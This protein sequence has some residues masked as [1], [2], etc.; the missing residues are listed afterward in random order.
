MNTEHE[1]ERMTCPI[2]ASQRDDAHRLHEVEP[3]P[4]FRAV[5]PR[6]RVVERHVERV[7]RALRRALLHL[8]ADNN[9]FGRVKC[10][11]WHRNLSL[12]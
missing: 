7:R 12:Q 10:A 11:R 1:H 5:L 8:L 6:E 3:G 2:V 4:L 9:A